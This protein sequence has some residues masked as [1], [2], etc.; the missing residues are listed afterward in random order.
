MKD[1]TQG[2]TKLAQL[3]KATGML[4][5][6]GSRLVSG[7]AGADERKNT[8]W[9]TMV[10]LDCLNDVFGVRRSGDQKVGYAKLD[11]RKGQQF[12][13]LAETTVREID[14]NKLKERWERWSASS[15]SRS[16]VLWGS[17]QTKNLC[18]SNDGKWPN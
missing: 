3:T 14:R 11:A 6:L 9:E 17:F 8:A 7:K 1:P 4:E 2:A 18:W 10:Y 15:S 12:E 13:E 16:A 5:T